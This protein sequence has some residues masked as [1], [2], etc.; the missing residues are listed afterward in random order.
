ML[1]PKSD[2]RFNFQGSSF[3]LNRASDVEFLGW[4][5][6]QF[7]YGEVTGIQCGHWLY[8]APTLQAATFLAKQAAEELSHVKRILRIQTLLNTKPKPA[9]GAVRFL[10]TGMMGGTWGE[11]VTLEMALGE[12]LVLT[13]FYALADLIPDPEIKKILESAIIDEEKHVIFGE[14]ETLKWLK[15]H[16]ED[17]RALLAQALLQSVALRRLKNFV[18]KK[19]PTSHPV[20]DKFSTFFDHTLFYFEAR[21]DLLGLT[22]EPISKMSGWKKTALLLALPFLQFKSRIFKRK[23]LL[24]DTYLKDAWVEN[25]LT[26]EK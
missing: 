23:R 9:H 1:I 12:G 15:Q 21:V 19:L 13:V 20:F 14:T 8:R 22:R 26:L 11:H 2:L 17:R 18:L 10:S 3:D 25:P 16:P 6:D 4:V 5:F 7:L 24:T